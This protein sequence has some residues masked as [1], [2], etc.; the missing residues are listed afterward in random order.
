MNFLLAKRL[1]PAFVAAVVL[2]VATGA[3][4]QNV[5]LP[6]A[7]G[8]VPATL[9]SYPFAGEDGSTPFA[10]L[11]RVGYVEE[12]YIIT[13]SANVYDWAQD[14]AVSVQTP[15]GSYGTRILVRRPSDP[16]RFN[17][18]VIFEPMF[19]AR[20]FDW[21]MMWGYTHNYVVESG[22]AW[23]GVTLPASTQ[24]MRKFNPTRYG[25]LSFENP[26][27]ACPTVGNAAPGGFPASPTEE[28]MKFD[29]F[30]QVGALLKSGTLNGL[31][32]QYVFATGQGGDLP[33]FINTVHSRSNFN[34]KPVFDGFVMR[35]GIAP[36]RIN[37]CTEA[38]GNNDPRRNIKA[39]NVPVVVV[40]AQGEAI[41]NARFRRPDA[42]AANDVFR[43]Y[44]V[45][46]VGHI[47]WWAYYGFPRYE[48]QVASV[49]SAQGPASWP[50]AVTCTPAIPLFQ[51]PVLGNA[52][53]AVFQN[54]DQF[55]R[56][57]TKLP[58][59]SPLIVKGAGTPEADYIYDQ[60]GHGTGGVRSVYVD[61]PSANYFTSSPGPGVC[62][63]MGYVNTW[64]WSKLE[65]TYG[66]FKS[67]ASK[68]EQSVD[69]LVRERWLTPGDARRAK[70]ELLLAS[71]AV[72]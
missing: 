48:D 53:N 1:A 7:T 33:T 47:D 36:T 37:E 71:P 21:P 35:P 2:C 66:S 4:A 44:E 54:L 24:G 13:G 14:G 45:A 5:P 50:F 55:V 31:R 23:V 11:S 68:A 34:G 69:R 15:N 52:Y 16:A 67:Y 32:A 59:S 29:M 38:P 10:N 61:V 51:A 8:P 30:A 27:I 39:A 65:Q 9:E 62:R 57:G 64:A 56:K 6:K 41:A 28:G 42:D 22:A 60:N 43:F 19:A 26:A 20:R 18:T 3:S 70:E 58:V 63:E 17:G 25:Q 72:R 49:G 40:A 12:E 46:G